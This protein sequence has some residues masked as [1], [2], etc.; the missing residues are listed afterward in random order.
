[1]VLI[2]KWWP[3]AILFLLVIVAWYVTF[4]IGLVPAHSRDVFDVG[5]GL[6]FGN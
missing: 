4:G 5:M 3:I 1:M 2:S 6:D